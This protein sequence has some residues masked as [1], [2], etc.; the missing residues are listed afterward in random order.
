MSKV[1]TIP[2]DRA[3]LSAFLRSTHLTASTVSQQIGFASGY[4]HQCMLKGAIGKDA[5]ILL[6]E[7]FG[8]E[9]DM[10]DPSKPIPKTVDD[11]GLTR[12]I[13]LF[14]DRLADCE[15]TISIRRRE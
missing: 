3:K 4:L 2:L 15:V 8:I 5:A 1:E 13:E 7:R 11:G 10:Y 6:Q 12:A 9:P 14:F